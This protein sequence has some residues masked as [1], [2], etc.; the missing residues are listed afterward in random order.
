MNL[1]KALALAAVMAT[2]GVSAA[3]Q[4]T[5]QS[6]NAVPT[7]V[8]PEDFKDWKLLCPP[9]KTAND[10]Q[11]CEAR[12]VKLSTE[13]KVLAILEVVT[14]PD[15]KTKQIAVVASVLV[16]LG[17]DLMVEPL[18]KV[19]DGKPM[20]MRYLLCL[21]RGCEARAPLAAEQQAAM[22]SGAKAKVAL[23]L[24]GSKSAVL[25]FSLNGFGAALDAM[26][27]KYPGAK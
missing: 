15:E 23:A 20:P 12:T 17:V 1:R 5:Q 10:P 9:P 6:P 22:R 3:A 19:D 25:D 16:P 24:G 8:K 13:G 27:K 7:A 14:V 21:P 26:K 11:V 4:E 18:F 2:I